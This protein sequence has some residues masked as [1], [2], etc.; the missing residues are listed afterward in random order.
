MGFDPSQSEDDR[1]ENGENGIADGVKV[2]GLVKA[3]ILGQGCSEFDI[4]EK[5]L[6]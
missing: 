5:L 1:V 3:D 4:L 2:V 6:E